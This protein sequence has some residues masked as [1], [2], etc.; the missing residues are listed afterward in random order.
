MSRYG[1]WWRIQTR[2]VTSRIARGTGDENVP[3]YRLKTVNAMNIF[4]KQDEPKK[5]AREKKKQTYAIVL[6][7]ILLFV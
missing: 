2:H 4:L 7:L 5:H 3:I 1:L 6:F